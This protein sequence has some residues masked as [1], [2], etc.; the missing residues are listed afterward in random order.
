MTL[1]V[2]RD[3]PDPPSAGDEEEAVTGVSPAAGA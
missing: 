1:L 3:M 2:L